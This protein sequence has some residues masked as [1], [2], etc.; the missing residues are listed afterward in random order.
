MF[1]PCT[2]PRVFALPPGVDFPRALVQ[3]LHQ[4]VAGQ[5]PH[6]LAGVQLVVNTHRMER[7]IRALFDAGPA[8]LLPRVSLVTDLTALGAVT[9]LPPAVP[10]LRRRLELVQLITR[11]LD[12]QPD[13]AARASIFDLSD[14]LAALID[15]MQGEGVTPAAIRALDVSDQSGHW[16][17]AQQFI[18]IAERYLRS[19]DDE[20]DVQARQ[21]RVVEALIAEWAQHPPEHPVILA[22]STGS[23]G[24]TMLLME[25]VARLP[26]GAVVLPGFDFDQPGRVWDGLEDALTAEDHPQF[27]FARLMARLGL[28]PDQIAPWSD[29]VAPCPSRNRLVS[30][31]LRP[32]PV[33]DAW[34]SEGPQL[35][36][37]DT[38]TRDITLIEA[39]SPRD[40]ALAIALRLRQAAEDGQ[41][42][43]LITPDRMLTRQVSAALDRWNIL[44]DD[45]AGLPLHL[46]P[47]GRF[48]RHVAGLFS[49]RLDG[50][51]LLTLLK[52]PLCHTGKGRNEHLLHTRDL[53]L[54]LRRNGPPFPGAEDLTGFATRREVSDGW[55]NW[56]ARCFCDQHVTGALPLSDWVDRLR[57]LAEALSAGAEGGSG[58]L[59]EQK[60][61]QEA[62]AVVTALADEAPHGGEMDARDF[63][64]LLG[65]LLSTGEVRD[66]DAP[67]PGIMI[68]GTLEAR[69]MGA[70]LLILGGLNEG[71]WPESPAP[72]PWL[73]R[74]MRHDA[75]LLLPERR[76]GLSA[77]D[78]QQ[79]IG[80]PEVWLT[81]AKRS[82]DAE[83]VP[84]RWLN[85]LTNLLQG[86][87][88]Q[89]GAVALSEMRARGRRWLSMAEALEEAPRSAPAPRPSPRPPLA[90]RPR[91]LS[92]TEI[93]KLI[94]DPYA[95]Y[96]RHVLRL[97]PLDP[98]VQ[99]P[100]ALLR[101]IVIH[102]V[103]ESFVRDSVLDMAL[104]NRDTFLKRAATML[105]E[106][107]AWP[108]AR[109]LW[110]ARLDR[111]A[112]AFLLSE[113]AR[114]ADAGPIAFEAQMHKQLDGLD[115]TLTGR[116]DRIDRSERGSLCLYDYKTGAPPSE[117]QQAKFDRQLL[118]EA[119]LAEEGGFEG[120]DPAPVARAVF[121]GM[122][123][124]Y[125]EVPAPLDAEPPVKVWA[126]LHQLIGAYFEP[127]QG[128]TSR[129]M[130]HKDSDAGDYDHL[131]RFGEWDRS[132]TPEPEDLT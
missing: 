50:E 38:A 111:V 73:N 1:D 108:T 27:R 104:L 67:Y 106:L 17:R 9:H 39:A 83:T 14:S 23:R 123:G 92:V 132:A 103:L 61:G 102:E 35:K 62:L 31:A 57:Q 118:I 26:Q 101:G 28:T 127:D 46:S 12:Q 48:L 131:A 130:L 70:D 56:V 74:R 69:V 93:K 82:D 114:R 4:R 120:I 79:A 71:S 3:G 44:P 22:G 107:V 124:S 76:I 122:G 81:R 19:G 77:H 13:L 84:S 55:T 75:G 24:T 40:E 87:P 89:G 117:K 98:L 33:T 2:H 47:P 116:A 37:I 121:I 54:D 63:A 99:A 105:E 109:A 91:Q 29:D 90:A 53:E 86:L 113:E 126:E 45:S 65:G 72:D 18:A 41:S 119:A 5:P 96:A 36:G 21:R 64:D 42:A 110:L 85:R 6:V 32:A 125:K 60:A 52:H 112:D 8:A 68:W 43:A 49:S 128:F 95:I 15:E 58:N 88:D 51:A 34:M 30:L 100:D 78:F 11:L 80:A 97:K 115:F 7:R 25:A 129:R 94:R 16:A 66:R 20:L 59:W 10:P